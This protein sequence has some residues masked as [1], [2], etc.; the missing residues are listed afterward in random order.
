MNVELIKTLKN[1]AV[2]YQ[3]RVRCL[4]RAM[5]LIWV[6]FVLRTGMKEQGKNLKKAEL[7]LQS[8]GFKFQIFLENC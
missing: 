6:G 2:L 8:G 7:V 4:G 5:S 1:P 3:F